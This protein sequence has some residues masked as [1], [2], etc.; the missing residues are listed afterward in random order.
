MAL[1]STIYRANINLSDIDRGVYEGPHSDQDRYVM[2]ERGAKNAVSSDLKQDAMTFP[3]EE[4]IT[5][6]AGL[7]L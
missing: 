5:K 1:P 2:N 3:A 4:R 7:L 6:M